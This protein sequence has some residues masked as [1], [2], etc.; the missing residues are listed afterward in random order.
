MFSFK[1]ASTPKKVQNLRGYRDGIRFELQ[2]VVGDAPTLGVLVVFRNQGNK[3]EGEKRVYAFRNFA[4][5]KDTSGA[6]G[7]SG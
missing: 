3:K 1:T 6:S 7:S 5:Q 4:S 2:D